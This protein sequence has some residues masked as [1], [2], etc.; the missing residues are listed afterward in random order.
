MTVPQY[1]CVCVVGEYLYILRGPVGPPPTEYFY[2][3]EVVD[4][5][6]Q[7][8]HRRSAVT[9]PSHGGLGGGDTVGDSLFI[10]FAFAI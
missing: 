10:Q 2:A 8:P 4:A 3:A 6:S 9:R 7:A 5:G 1:T